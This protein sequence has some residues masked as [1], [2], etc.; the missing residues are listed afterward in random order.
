M[1]GFPRLAKMA[2]ARPAAPAPTMT[3]SKTSAPL[4]WP[5]VVLPPDDVFPLNA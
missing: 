2:V 4:V 3:T 5:A 1:S